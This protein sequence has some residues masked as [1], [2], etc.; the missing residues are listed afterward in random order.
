MKKNQYIQP[1][2]I[3]DCVATAELIA[4]SNCFT[5]EME[6]VNFNYDTMNEGDGSDAASRRL[7]VWDDQEED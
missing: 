6:S 3:V 1:A 4:A 2:T 7:S 5:S